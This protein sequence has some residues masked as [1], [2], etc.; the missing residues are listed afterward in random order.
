VPIEVF[1]PSRR[2]LGQFKSRFALQQDNW[3]DFGFQSLY[4]L[5]YSA[6][7]PGAD[8]VQIGPVK[9]LRHGQRGSDRL[10]ITRSFEDLPVD[11][12]SVGAS[13]DYERL[14]QPCLS[15]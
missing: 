1:P 7:E 6:R 9:I 13:L 12:C 4:H 3:N 8:V 2:P 10:L 5:Y 15:G 14:N 11:F